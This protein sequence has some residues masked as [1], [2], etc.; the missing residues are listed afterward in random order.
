MSFVDI[1]V[2]TGEIADVVTRQKGNSL[3][4]VPTPGV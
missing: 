2:K 4:D 3:E 1:N